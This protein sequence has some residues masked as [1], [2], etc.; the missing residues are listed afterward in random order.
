MQGGRKG[1][2]SRK[3]GK[4]GH[5]SGEKHFTGKK[6]GGG[7]ARKQKLTRKEKLAKR[8]THVNKYYDRGTP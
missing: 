4:S 2:G 7:S 8:H 3:H 6:G 5:V 1:I